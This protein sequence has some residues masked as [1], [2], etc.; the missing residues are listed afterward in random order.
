[1]IYISP[2]D[3]SVFDNICQ[4]A[5]DATLAMKQFFKSSELNDKN[6]F[7]PGGTESDEATLGL[8]VV[9]RQF[10]LCGQVEV[11]SFFH[12]T[13]QEYLAAVHIAG[14]DQSKQQQLVQKYSGNS[15]LTLVWKFVCGTLDYSIEKSRVIFSHILYSE[16]CMDVMT[17]IYFAHESQQEMGCSYVVREGALRLPSKK[18]LTISDCTALGYVI[19]KAAAVTPSKRIVIYFE[20]SYFNSA[21]V[22]AFL[23]QVVHVQLDLQISLVNLHDYTLSMKLAC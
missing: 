10:A 9:D 7:K 6:I 23:Q 12:L 1:M 15:A 4:L 8:V 2:E 3:K 16:A 17:K 19:S 11:Y 21:G 18:R 13:F 20:N 5:F 22:V 14:L